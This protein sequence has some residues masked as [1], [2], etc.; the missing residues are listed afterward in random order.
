A[1]L[2]PP[3]QRAVLTMLVLA[4]P[5][6]VSTDRLVDGLWG[7]HP[8]RHP[9]AALRVHIHGVRAAL[10]DIS[11]T[12]QVERVAPGYRL[13]ITAEQ[14]DIGRF[15]MLQQRVRHAGLR[16]ERARGAST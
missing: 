16:Q 6:V 1:R 12:E 15:A 3:R 14:T 2:G 7:G 4:A 8:P 5:D 13:G 10:R 11:E 9:L